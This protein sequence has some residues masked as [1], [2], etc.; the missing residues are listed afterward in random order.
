[1]PENVKIDL[2]VEDVVVH[3]TAEGLVDVEAVV[4]VVGEVGRLDVAA[5]A[6]LDSDAPVNEEGVGEGVIVV[7]D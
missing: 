7:A 4:L 5:G 2:E 3:A 1:M 6:D